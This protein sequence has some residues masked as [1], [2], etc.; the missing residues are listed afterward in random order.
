MWLGSG[1][2][3]PRAGR[4]SAASACGP[5][6]LPRFTK[7]I[8][9]APRAPSGAGPWSIP[10]GD[11]VLWN[12]GYPSDSA[13]A[14]PPDAASEQAPPRVADRVV[15]GR[16][17]AVLGPTNTGKTH[18]AITR[19]LG[20]ASGMIGLP[21]RLLARE[22]YDRVVAEKGPA[23]VA[24]ITGEE[25]I[26]PANPRWYVCT[27]EAMPRDLATDFLA[28]D[29]IQLCADPER[30]HVFTDRL[31]RARGRE[32]TLFLGADSA[33]G[34]IRALVPG[35]QFMSRRR[36]STLSYAGQKKLSRL[37]PR[38]AIVAFSAADVYALAELVRRQRGGAAVVLGALSPRT[39]NAQ[40]ALYQNRDVDYLVATDAIGMGLNM[41]IDHVAFAGMRKFD[42][43]Q[44]RFLQPAEVAQVAGRAGR[45]MRDGSF[46]TTADMG[47]LEPEL[48]ERVELHNFDMLRRA[49]WRNPGLDFR[50]LAA[51]RESL[52]R[53]PP[54]DRL[55]RGRES[56]DDRTLRTLSQDAAVADLTRSP[57]RVRLLW[58][59]CGVPDFRKTMPEAHARL[60][61][62]LY[63][64]LAGQEE[65]LPV[66]W[67]ARSID[68]LDRSDGDIDTL[69]MRI[70][71]IRT[72]TY[73]SH[74]REWLA[75][76][77][78]WQDRARAIE[79]RLSDALHERL[80]QRFVD[81]RTSV[82]M[83]RLREG[84]DLE[85]V[86]RN[87]GE[88][89]VEG[90]FVGRIAGL[91]F[92]ADSG[93]T[94]RPPAGSEARTVQTAARRVLNGALKRRAA[95]LEK[96]ADTSL[97]LDTAT[98]CIL[99]Q[100]DDHAAPAGQLVAGS[101]VLRPGIRLLAHE[102][103]D[104]P[105]RERAAARLAAWLE[106]HV[107]QVLA[108]LLRLPDGLTGPARGLA[109]R[110][111]ERLGTV[112]RSEMQDLSRDIGR[113][114][115]RLLRRQGIRIGESGA[116][117]PQLL[118]PA[119]M[120]L[121]CCLFAIH[122]G[123]AP[124]PAPPRPGLTSLSVREHL[125]ASGTEAPPEGWWLA[126]G[127]MVFGDRAVRFDMLDRVA[128]ATRALAREG[129][130][131]ADPGLMSLMGCSPEDLGHVLSGLGYKPTRGEDGQLRYQRRHKRGK[132]EAPRRRKAEEK[133]HQAVH[134]AS[135]FAPLQQLVLAGQRAP[136]A[137]RG[138]GPGSGTAG[139]ADPKGAPKGASG[140]RRRGRPR[141]A[142]QP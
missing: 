2:V 122:A 135:P 70:A 18:Y 119:P 129:P 98:G 39:R 89:T 83:R 31:L 17:T 51:L 113:D 69:A 125:A 9:M 11:A 112:P 63:L 49:R 16:V 58:E 77:A 124:L 133:R 41:D 138:T 96:V 110:L 37:P 131:P 132:T 3:K 99:W 23:S 120:Q 103:L 82:L 20:H 140:G 48:I 73:V 121:K 5:C 104:G 126:A 33:R 55:Q 38:S 46:G 56:D 71:H 15:G 36:L 45:H 60:L 52:D 74:R 12:P 97:S 61:K 53:P 19:M 80:T 40:V 130:V 21:L 92:Q 59:V 22:V 64:H 128:D 84:A 81:R 1:Q 106:G 27:V 100:E 13:N 76:A 111:S 95:V 123:L 93:Q 26:R 90:E 67:V 6:N 91:Q 72:W 28:V 50:S 86:V 142:K 7:I 10:L 30:G 87:N 117:M 66:D 115:R 43:E 32:E 102:A 108:P 25:K 88:V 134:A 85:A 24:L 127:F 116:F 109:F 78:H 118:K 141:Q 65:V 75:D 94:E 14:M 8:V 47:P 62:R 44:M 105:A 29:E 42:G 137:K 136:G 68:R 139:K 34:L 101:A 107:A 114:D 79:D 57:A 4:D 35:A 54:H